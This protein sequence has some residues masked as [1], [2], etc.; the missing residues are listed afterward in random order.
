MNNNKGVT[1]RL[2]IHILC[3]IEKNEGCNVMDVND[4]LNS[5]EQNTN[6]ILE[7]YESLQDEV[8]KKNDLIIELQNTIEE[9]N[10]TIED[11][12]QIIN[13]KSNCNEEVV[14]EFGLLGDM[15]KIQW[16]IE[17]NAS[18][19][20]EDNKLVVEGSNRYANIYLYYK[21]NEGD[22]VEGVLTK[23]VLSIEG[24]VENGCT[25]G[26]IGS[27]KYPIEKSFKKDILLTS[28]WRRSLFI[29]IMLNQS[30]YETSKLFIS[31][32]KLVLG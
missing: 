5:L 28:T 32:M 8:S 17:N 11:Q 3:I 15:T 6:N 24:Y 1:C 14:G 7:K 29:R 22:Y 25:N 30:Q 4:I 21:E 2:N 23:Y 10:K 27:T 12:K 20:I 26:Y 16:Q 9:K 19:Y 18:Y 13:S 31:K